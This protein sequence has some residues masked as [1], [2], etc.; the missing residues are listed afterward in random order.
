MAPA[1][2]SPPARLDTAY[3][4]WLN[5][6][7]F[8]LR[9]NQAAKTRQFAK[10]A[11]VLAKQLHYERGMLNAHF[12]L[13]Y[14]YRGASKYD[15]ALYHTQQALSLA[16]RLHSSYD[17]TRGLYNLGRIHF[18][19]GDYS[20]ALAIN[21]QGLALAQAIHNRR[22][23][24]Y[25]LIQ[26]GLI[27]IALGE[28][29]AAQEHFDQALLLAQSLK[30]NIGI[31][32]AYSGLGDLNRQQARWSL[33]GHYY[34]SAAASYHNVFNTQGMLPVELSIA[35]M[36]E[37]QGNHAA[38]ITAARSL[39]RQTLQADWEGPAA[40]AQLLL[41]RIYL[42]TGLY[43]SA[44]YYAARSLAL[45]RGHGLRPAIRDAAQVLA[46]ANAQLGQWHRAYQYRALAIS[47]ADSLTGEDTRRRVAGLLAQASHRRQQIQLQLVQQQGRLQTQQQEL[48]R[49][50]YHQQ[51]AA[52]LVLA[53]LLVCGGSGLLW[54]YRRREI[55]RHEA[56]RT[57]IAA[58]LHD[59][60]GSML[61][62]ISM[63]ST[64]LR[65]GRYAPAQQQE[66]LDQ[67]AEASRR[68]ARQM[69]DAVWSI[70]A[71]YDSAASL[72]DRL[73]DHAHEVLPPA[74]LEL[75]FGVE[76]T[77]ANATVP[78]ATRQALYYIYKEALH[79]VVKH[80]HARQVHVR[81]RLRQQLEL[82]VRDDGD[83]LV[84][85]SRS[86]GQGLPNMRMRAQAVGGTIRL[87]AAEPGTRLVVRLPL[88]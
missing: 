31:G 52:L 81:L 42:A 10:Q 36:T 5:K 69:R 6:Q 57:R 83:G 12:S 76:T 56:L 49:L 46:E 60:V 38:A 67:M 3:V 45:N 14:Y 48:V 9:I 35:E 28:Y 85:P 50:R 39:L 33:A 86:S 63:Q 47:Y 72:L 59:E 55:S 25:Q 75:D 70:D 37:R 80:A 26:A 77:I 78:L 4:N 27:E 30:D 15:S 29:A 1:Q 22:A 18:E 51:L 40:R 8:L 44:S 73:R 84:S 11:L 2:P 87:E 74:G 34:T 61:T 20:G 62:Q 7:A 58:D 82:E 64:L 65:E 66:Y 19:Q 68:A 24:L 23:E 79:N 88:R 54:H 21:L 32:G 43:D 13:G 71:R 41:G 53:L 17:R 16:S